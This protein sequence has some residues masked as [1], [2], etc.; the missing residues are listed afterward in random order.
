[1]LSDSILLEDWLA[2]I[3]N[4]QDFSFIVNEGDSASAIFQGT[5]DFEHVTWMDGDINVD[6]PS[7][8][9]LDKMVL[10]AE[11]LGAEVVG[12]SGEIYPDSNPNYLHTASPD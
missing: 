2:L 7:E 3:E 12:A 11:S 8:Q 5:G 9:L 4:D 10:L 6:R 1:M